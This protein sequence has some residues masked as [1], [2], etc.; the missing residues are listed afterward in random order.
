M[1]LNDFE[2]HIDFTI[3]GRGK[4][5]FINGAVSDPEEI[6]P[7]HWF[8]SVYG[9]DVYSAGIVLDPDDQEILDWHCSCPYDHGPVCKHVVALLYTLSENA[10][11]NG[12]RT[13]N[14]KAGSSKPANFQEIIDGVSKEELWKFIQEGMKAD[15]QL[16]NRFLVHFAEHATG[17]DPQRKYR[18]LI[19]GC[20][21]QALQRSGYDY[22]D[23]YSAA[24][25]TRP[26]YELNEKADQLLALENIQESL[27]ICKSLIEEVSG[28]IDTIDDSDG[29]A[30]NVITFS[31][32]TLS[33]MIAEA[34]FNEKEELFDWCLQEYSK[35]KYGDFGFE[36][37][38]LELMPGLVVNPEQ[39][40]R[41][42]N[43]IDKKVDIVNA[44]NYSEYGIKMLVRAKVDYFKRSGRDKEAEELINRYSHI[45]E[46]REMQVEIAL[47]SGN[48]D[49]A[50]ELCL[51]GVDIGKKEKHFGNINRWY[52]WLFEIAKNQEDISEI[53]KYAEILLFKN[54]FNMVWYRQ[55]KASWPSGKWA[56]KCEEI[57]DRIK[58]NDMEWW[59]WRSDSLAEI[60]IEEGYSERLLRLARLNSN[61]IRFI[62]QY[63]GHLADDYPEEIL[64][65][66]ENAIKSFAEQ[67]GRKY[68]REASRYLKEMSELEGGN[69]KACLLCKELLQ[70]YN[71][72]PAMKDEFRKKFPGWV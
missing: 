14:N 39:E 26:L 58:G 7:G 38:F 20:Y 21:N 4:D 35:T 9:S 50:K 67:T 66:Y 56:E 62:R 12:N 44:S 17:K 25:F 36:H 52:E 61:D 45:A 10:I 2:Q 65:F 24:I 48:T 1:N 57:I 5:Y 31:F 68:Y 15:P 41:F 64:T 3:L 60:Y 47:E 54:H 8:A 16:K 34:G 18:T 46:F 70:T 13:V 11:E 49:L 22:I 55:L 30:G 28:V 53:R 29:G 51:E 23:Y 27:A 72:R 63:A 42:L 71:N 37:H 33:K 59:R 43:L 32:D 69:D 19:K 6:E 40:E